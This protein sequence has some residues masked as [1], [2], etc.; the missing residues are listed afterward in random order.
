MLSLCSQIRKVE[1]RFWLQ[2]AI[3][4]SPEGEVLRTKASRLE[5]KRLPRC[6]HVGSDV[7]EP[8]CFAS[9]FSLCQSQQH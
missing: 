2:K 6:L 9:R 3:L 1:S 7:T 5:R 8:S 4:Y